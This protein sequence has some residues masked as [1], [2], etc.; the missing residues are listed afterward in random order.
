MTLRFHLGRLDPVL[1][2]AALWALRAH[3]HVRHT[4]VAEDLQGIDLAGP[5][6]LPDR[7]RRGVEAAL[8]RRGAT[9]L[10]ETAVLQRWDAAHG[11]PRDIIIG[12]TSP[13]QGFRAHA[14]LDGDP[15]EHLKDFKELLRVR[16]R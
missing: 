4:L 10:M 1:W 3:H 12:V 13:A 2:R 14:W 6:D 5:P 11:R 7:G 8:R 9:C 15:D 16:A